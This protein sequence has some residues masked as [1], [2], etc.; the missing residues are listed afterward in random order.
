VQCTETIAGGKVLQKVPAVGYINRA[1]N[2]M[3]RAAIAATTKANVVNTC[4]C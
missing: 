2:E 4:N 3:H 1:R